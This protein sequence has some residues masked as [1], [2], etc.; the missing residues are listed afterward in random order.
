MRDSILTMGPGQHFKQVL[1]CD[2]GVMAVL[3]R[4]IPKVTLIMP[5]DL[6][7][8]WWSR[9]DRTP[10]LM[11]ASSNQAIFLNSKIKEV[12]ASTDFQGFSRFVT[13]AHSLVSVVC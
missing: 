2:R 5:V 1:C 12:A 11:T 8:A 9:G 6:L 10:D 3:Q 4:S 7:K 13:L